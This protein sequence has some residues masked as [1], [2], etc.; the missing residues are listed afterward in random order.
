MRKNKLI[1]AFL[2]F[3]LSICFLTGQVNSTTENTCGIANTSETTNNASVQK[4]DP[5]EKAVD[6]INK[7]LILNDSEKAYS[8]A[9]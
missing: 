8:Y 5:V 1:L 4:Q 2:L 7:N 6:S 3:I 9:R